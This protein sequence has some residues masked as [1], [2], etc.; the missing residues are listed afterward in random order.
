MGLSIFSAAARSSLPRGM[1]SRYMPMI[2]VSGSRPKYS[3]KSTSSRSSLLPMLANFAMPMFS[4]VMKF[5]SMRPTPP[6]WVM[7]EK[8]P[9]GGG[10]RG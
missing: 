10:K 1:L 6:L 5:Q 8:P 4:S 9:L 2:F 3:R 7:I